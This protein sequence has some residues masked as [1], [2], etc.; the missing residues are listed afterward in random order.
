[1]K[2]PSDRKRLILLLWLIFQLQTAI[3]GHPF[4]IL[5]LLNVLLWTTNCQKCICK[6]IIFFGSLY[7]KSFPVTK[8]EAKVWSQIWLMEP[9]QP[10]K[11]FLKNILT[12]GCQYS[13]KSQRVRALFS[14][15]VRVIVHDLTFI[16]LASGAFVGHNLDIS[17][18]L[19]LD[20]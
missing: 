9:F 20:K 16:D 17:D 5:A 3:K 1:M 14:E 12:K 2:N 8:V 19:H 13:W 11:N 7:K 10:N 18:I 15:E 4:N 6:V